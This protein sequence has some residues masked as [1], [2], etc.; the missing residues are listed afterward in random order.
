MIA[1]IGDE[2]PAVGRERE[3]QGFPELSVYGGP[4]ISCE[5]PFFAADP[6]HSGDEALRVDLA[7]AVVSGVGHDRCDGNGPV[8]ALADGPRARRSEWGVFG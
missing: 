5:A 8:A 2:Q 6:G 3:P 1:A 7:H 4:T